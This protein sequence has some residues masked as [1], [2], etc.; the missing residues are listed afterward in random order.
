MHLHSTEPPCLQPSAQQR[1]EQRRIREQHQDLIA[2]Y[3]SSGTSY[4]PSA[5]GTVYILASH[6]E[7]A[8]N[9]TLWYV[10]VRRLL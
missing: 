10:F 7:L 8:V 1:R 5:S 6:L 3:Y 9:E 4:G 2:K